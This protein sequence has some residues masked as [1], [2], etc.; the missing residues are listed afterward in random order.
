MPSAWFGMGRAYY[1]VTAWLRHTEC[2][3]YFGCGTRSVPTTLVTARGACLLLWRHADC[4]YYFSRAYLSVVIV[5]AIGKVLPCGS[6]LVVNSD[7]ESDTDT[8]NEYRTK[9]RA[10][11]ASFDDHDAFRGRQEHTS[12][13]EIVGDDQEERGTSAGQ[14]QIGC[15]SRAPASCEERHP[16]VLQSAMRETA[17]RL[18]IQRPTLLIWCPRRSRSQSVRRSLSRQV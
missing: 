7:W 5:V 12:P 3:Y 16:G 6:Q 11:A 2:A 14:A 4:G 9:T 10:R 15:R 13:Q 1:L 17:A 18:A 8:G